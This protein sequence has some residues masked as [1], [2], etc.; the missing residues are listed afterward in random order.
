MIATGHRPRATAF[1]N[2]DFILIETKSGYGRMQTDPDAPQYLLSTDA[3]DA[4]IGNSVLA[5]LSRSRQIGLDEVATFFDLVRL[6][7]EYSAWIE[8]LMRIYGYKARRAL[9]KNMMNVS[10][11]LEESGAAIR[12][13]P[14]RHKAS[15]SWVGDD[16]I[17]DVIVPATSSATELGAA[18]R[19]ALSRCI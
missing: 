1:S 10:I 16:D 9:F 13:T 8:D 5:A 14:M 7:K 17:E 2:E 18:F 12:F 11:E 4:E 19:I 15:D 3:S 6:E